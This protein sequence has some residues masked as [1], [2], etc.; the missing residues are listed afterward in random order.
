MTSSGINTD[1]QFTH[2]VNDEPGCVYLH[3]TSLIFSSDE[4]LGH[5]TSRHTYT[6]VWQSVVRCRSAGRY[7]VVCLL[8]RWT[9]DRLQINNISRHFNIIVV[10]EMNWERARF[11][12]NWWCRYCSA[13]YTNRYSNLVLRLVTQAIFRCNMFTSAI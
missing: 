4:T 11:F 10:D 13:K 1:T 9:A 12:N 7:R 2:N 3:S 5:G 8:R 6:S